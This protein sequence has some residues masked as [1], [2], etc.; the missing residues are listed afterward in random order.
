M[1]LKPLLLLLASAMFGACSEPSSSDDVAGGGFETSD[2]TAVAVDSAGSQVI[3]AR[4][5]LVQ[6][7]SDSAAS[8]LPLDSIL[9]GSAGSAVFA[10]VRRHG[11]GL[12]VE[13][14]SGDTL[15]GF[16]RVPDS[17][18]AGTVRVTLRRTRALYLPC[19]TQAYNAFMAPGTHFLQHAPAVCQDSFRILVP[20]NVRRLV[21]VPIDTLSPRYTLPLGD[22]LPP[23]NTYLPGGSNNPWRPVPGTGF[24]PP[25][26]PPVIPYPDSATMYR[27]QGG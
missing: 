24:P 4:V 20:P 21:V 1:N 14:W 12:G 27:Y 3:G 13:A 10:D 5:W 17:L 23:W 7:Q 22:S 6:G 16:A 2:L 11:P 15:F 25:P 26:P 18:A 8:Q 19:S 9:V